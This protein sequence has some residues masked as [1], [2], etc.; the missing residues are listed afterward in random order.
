MDMVRPG[1][2]LYGYYPDESLDGLAEEGLRPVMTVKSR[3]AALRRLP[4]GTSISYGRTAALERDSLV[5]VI[6][7]GY[8][9]GLPRSLSNRAH[10]RIGGTLC[11]ILGRVCMDMCMV[12]VT[13]LEQLQ[14][15]EEVVVY[16]GELALRNAALTGTI[17]YELLC[18]LSPRVPRVYVNG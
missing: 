10:V 2:S 11:P 6:P 15:G 16:D 5:A 12:D 3:I 9:D 17:V 4:K 18:D 7:M 8:G 14:V 13:G 1:I